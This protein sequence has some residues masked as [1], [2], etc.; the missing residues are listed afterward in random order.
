MVQISSWHKLY[1]T[2]NIDIRT[3]LQY[4]LVLQFSCP[5]TQNWIFQIIILSP[6]WMCHGDGKAIT[7]HTS[8]T[9]LNAAVCTSKT[10]WCPV[11]VMLRFTSNGIMEPYL[12]ILQVYIPTYVVTM[13]TA[14]ILHRITFYLCKVQRPLLDLR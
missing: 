14:A 3:H 5:R 13:H 9:F 2:V 7:S 10:I 11:G 4:S 12:V 1:L 6:D 8:E